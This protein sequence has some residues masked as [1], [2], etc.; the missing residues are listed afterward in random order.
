[1]CDDVHVCV[2]HPP[3]IVLMLL[4][5]VVVMSMLFHYVFVCGCIA[6]TVFVLVLYR[7]YNV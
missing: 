6:R 7:L 2:C 5:V 4:V 1:M 3:A